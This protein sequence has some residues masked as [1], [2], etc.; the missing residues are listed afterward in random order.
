MHN[1][2]SLLKS[3]QAKLS[4]KHVPQ[5]EQACAEKLVELGAY[6]RQARQTQAISLEQVAAQT[7]IRPRLLNA[8]EQGRLEQLPEPVYIQGFIKR[9]AEALGLDGAELAN[10]FPTGVVLRPANPSWRNLPAAQLRPMHL[11]LLYIF[12]IICAVNGLSYLID[13]S[14][15]PNLGDAKFEQPADRSPDSIQ[16]G[17][18]VAPQS[19]TSDS[20]P[21]NQT[22]L[23][24]KSVQVSVTMKAQSWILVVSDGKTE[25]EGVLAEGT[26]RS[27]TA[28]QQLTL[29]AGNAGGVLVALNNGEAKQLGTLG[30]VEEVTFKA[31]ADSAA[32]ESLILTANR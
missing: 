17:I 18:A 3:Y 31:S 32:V 22:S 6:L 26:Q 30:S 11:Y 5:A 2:K 1:L 23:T 8:I 20:L 13:R 9:F 4:K 10:A 15:T 25:F 7:K 28:N 21:L 29:R 27:W 24:N 14:P 12:L 16:T 19:E